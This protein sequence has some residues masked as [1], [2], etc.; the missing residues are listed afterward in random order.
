MVKIPK[1]IAF[2]LLGAVFPLFLITENVFP[3]ARAIVEKGT[4][5][6]LGEARFQTRE[7]GS[8]P[9]QLKMLEIHI[10]VINHSRTSAAPPNS[11][12]VLVTP[13]EMKFPEGTPVT[14]FALNPEEVT[15]NLPLPPS[16]GR[17]LIIGFSL[18]EAK[19]ESITF[20]I[21]INPPDGEKKTVKWE[22]GEPR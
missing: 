10:E 2:C 11:I 7:I 6:R 1:R 9:S 8:P 22:G 13:K 21:Q 17:V 19:P 3:Q 14:E 20:E 12:K 5:I 4:D 16:T 18:L 15:L